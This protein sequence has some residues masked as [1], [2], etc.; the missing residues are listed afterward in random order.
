M[1]S[2]RNIGPWV[3]VAFMVVLNPA[4]AKQPP[5]PAAHKSSVVEQFDANGDGWLNADE[6]KAA[7]AAVVGTG[8][9]RRGGSAA[10]IVVPGVVLTPAQVKRYGAE[11]LYDLAT[12]RTLFISF[13]ENDWEQELTD[14]YRTDVDVPATVIVDGKTLTNVGVHFHGN[15]SFQMVGTGQ[16]RSLAL[17][18]AFIDKK[19]TLL[20]YGNLHLLNSAADPTFLRSAL[21]MHIM[22]TYIPAPQANYVRVVINGENWGVYV[23]QQHLT[24]EFAQAAGGAHKAAR[25]KVPGNPRGHGGLEYLGDDPERYR[26]IYDIKSADR[27]ESWTALITLC[28]VLNTTPPDHLQAAPAPL[29]D[30]DGTLKF[31]A[32]DKVLINND[33]Y[34]TRASDYSLFVD[35]KGRF[36]LTPYDANETLRPMESSGW[37]RSG[38]ANDEAGRVELDPLAGADDPSKALLYRLLAVPALRQRYLALVRDVTDQWLRWDR[39]GPLA[40]RYQAVIAA[41]VALDTR[42]LYSTAAFNDTLEHD[43]AV[44]NY[45]GPIAPP[46]MSLKTF[47]EER[48][49]YL[50]A[51]LSA[52]EQKP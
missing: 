35:A 16:K 37:G 9:R 46:L 31:L 26:R 36:H 48:R 49:A 25:W 19:Q 34:W 6:R 44:E 28:K 41:D 33:G 24:A 20:G 5:S 27:P 32:I 38:V 17:D 2:N 3:L 21:Y 42:K 52:L 45:G 7:R 18:F 15:T 12:L 10:T 4:L 1:T 22:R 11:P 47:T 30:V 50:L 39:L 51:R 29:L 8:Y 13:Q 14:F 40:R 43:N 23:N